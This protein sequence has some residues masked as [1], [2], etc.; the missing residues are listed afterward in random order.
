MHTWINLGTLG[1]VESRATRPCIISPPPQWQGRRKVSKSRGGGTSNNVKGVICPLIRI[2][3]MHLRKFVGKQP[4]PLPPAL[5]FDGPDC[6]K[7]L[8]VHKAGP[9]QAEGAG[10]GHV[11]PPHF[12]AD[13]LT[14]S[15]PGGAHYTHHITTCHPGFSDLA[16]ALHLSWIYDFD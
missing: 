14:L 5:G 11:P 4:S 7:A 2:V 8:V 3:L 16:T 15:Q 13:Q 6:F 9:S 10:G 1:S 12:S